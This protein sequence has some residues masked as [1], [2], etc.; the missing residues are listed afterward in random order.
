MSKILSKT[1]KKGMLFTVIVTVI[2]AAALVI[3]GIFGF[4][5]DISGS[6]YKTISVKMDYNTYATKETEVKEECDKAFGSLDSKLIVGGEMEPYEYELLYV[7]DKDADVESV[8][9]ALEAKFDALVEENA[10]WNGAD[11][12]VS[13]GTEK[14]VGT[15]AKN[16]VLRGVI[17]GAVL[18]VLAFVYVSIRYKLHRGIFAGVAS[19]VG[20]LL[21]TAIVVITRVPVTPAIAYVI[22]A[23]ALLTLV[24]V[25][26]N[27]N[28]LRANEKEENAEE[29]SNA[30]LIV[31]SVAKKEIVFLTAALGGAMLLVG[32][33][34]MMSTCWFAVAS[35]IA[36]AVAAFIGLIYAPAAYL[37]VKEWADKRPVKD[38]FAYKG[39]KKK[40]EKETASATEKTES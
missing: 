34:G 19:V 21:T 38:K 16:Y 14:V 5:S 20:I 8:K 26:L 37:P 35:L 25:I 36:I 11:I 4:N 27:F 17:A 10:A 33:L 32:I 40:E 6:D 9:T 28:K 3:G 7:F 2:L 29:K 23:S 30:D 15:T 24:G 22:A 13:T 18:A 39:A 1:V 12:S 31:E